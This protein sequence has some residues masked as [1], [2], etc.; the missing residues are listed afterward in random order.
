MKNTASEIF[1][2]VDLKNMELEGNSVVDRLRLRYKEFRLWEGQAPVTV[3][4]DATLTEHFNDLKGGGFNRLT[5]I[6]VPT[7]T[8]FPVSGPDPRPAVL[9]SPGGGYSYLAWEHE[10]IAICNWLNTI[11]FHAFLLKYRCP[12]RREAAFADAARAIRFIRANQELFCVSKIGCIGFSAGGHLC[13]SITAPANPVPYEPVDEID[14][15]SFIPDYTALIY[16]AYL[17]NKETLQ[18]EPEFNVNAETP[19]TF[20]IQTQDDGINV[21]NAIAWYLAMKKANAPCEMHLFAEGGHGYGLFRRG[22]PVNEWD[23][24]AGKW[25]RRM[26]KLN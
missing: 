14:D 24:P 26:A 1:A 6:T 7:V 15:L 8:Y 19:P 16:P 4:E 17:A 2:P 20:I 21:E 13:A 5:D 23:T 12:A 11:G 18:L 25:F 22:L 3:P 9:V 10:G